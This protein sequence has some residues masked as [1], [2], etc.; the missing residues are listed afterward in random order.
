MY[1]PQHF[2]E[3]RPDVLARAIRE[4]Q[5][6]LLVTAVDGDYVASHVPMV[7]K[8]ADG[9]LTLEAH[10]ARP[11]R[12]WTVLGSRPA[13]LAVFQGPHTYVSPSWYESKRQHGKVVP[14]WNYV[15]VHAH[16]ALEVVED[17]DWLLAH[18]EDLVA[19]N[20]SGRDQPWAISDAPADFV[21]AMTRAIVGLRLTVRRL[22]GKWKMSQNRS[23]ADRL[24]TM[25]GLSA[26]ADPQDQA[27]AAIMQALEMERR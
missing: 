12:H 13:A 3:E 8:N 25:A 11:N 27:V 17:R 5:F 23:Q 10:V 21:D 18:L 20:E 2:Q 1:I 15:I 26:S 6:A 16:G 22:E 9:A 7:L 4:I 14:T 24:G 19:A